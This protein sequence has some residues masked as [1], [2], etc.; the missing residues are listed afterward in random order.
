MIG[1]TF[2]PRKTRKLIQS[3]YNK[4]HKGPVIALDN[5]YATVNINI[6]IPNFFSS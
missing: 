6:S 4:V 5:S 1:F 3:D 2:N